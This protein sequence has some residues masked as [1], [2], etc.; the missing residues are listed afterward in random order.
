MNAPEAYIQFKQGLITANGQVTGSST[1]EFLRNY[2][3]E[4]HQFITR[5]CTALPTRE[6]T[7]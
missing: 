3:S 6:L 2:M 5:V 1:A 4:F 7:S